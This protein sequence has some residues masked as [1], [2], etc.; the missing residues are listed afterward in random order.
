MPVTSQFLHSDGVFVFFGKKIIHAYKERILC[1]SK[2]FMVSI[3]S[4]SDQCALSYLVGA[5]LG[6]F[7]PFFCFLPA[8][9]KWFRVPTCIGRHI[10]VHFIPPLFNVLHLARKKRSGHISFLAMLRTPSI[11]DPMREESVG[12]TCTIMISNHLAGSYH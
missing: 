8:S 3:F 11:K 10:H 5:Y 9:V 6:G 7:F 1:S 12:V 2:H 4:A